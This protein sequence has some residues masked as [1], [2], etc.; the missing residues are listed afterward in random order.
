LQKAFVDGAR[1][2]EDVFYKLEKGRIQRGGGMTGGLISRS[3]LLRE[4][5]RCKP[6]HGETPEELAVEEQWNQ[7]RFLVEHAQPF[8]SIGKWICTDPDAAQYC[9][10]IDDFSWSYIEVRRL[11]FE[12]K[13]VV[14]HSVIDLRDY[15]IDEL[16]QY[17]GS[18]YSSYEQIVADYGFKE[19]LH[20]IA[21]CVFEQ[22]GFNDME[23]NVEKES[24]SNAVKFICKWIKDER[25]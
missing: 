1:I 20:I 4:F 13:W 3:A 22:L 14:C 9:K 8:H 15:T 2:K 12:E 10:R 25:L 6:E 17:C 23:F 21:E 11:T 5:D 16:W 7:D 18:Y 19:S 24:F